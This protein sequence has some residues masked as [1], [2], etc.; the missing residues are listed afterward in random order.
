MK[1]L[2]ID[3]TIENIAP[4]TDFVN[5]ELAALNCPP[6]VQRQID[7]AIDE[8]FGNIAQYAYDPDVGP[9]TVRVEVMEEPL[10]VVIT[11]IDHG[12]PYDPL[13]QE[14]PGGLGIFLVRKTMDDVTYE[15]KNGQNILKIKK[16]LA[17]GGI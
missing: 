15:Y 3:A 17:G 12:V 7:V 4:V 10:A 2:S 13:S 5:G 1:E 11:F 16:R 6:K 8:L 14:A 9:A